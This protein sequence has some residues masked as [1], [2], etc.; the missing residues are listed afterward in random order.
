VGAVA[1]TD[2]TFGIP[3][4]TALTGLDKP[5]NVATVTGTLST[6]TV[7]AWGGATSWISVPVTITRLK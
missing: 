4:Y 7:G 6:S 1:S 2:V 3:A 5:A